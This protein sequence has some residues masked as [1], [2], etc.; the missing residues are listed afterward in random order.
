MSP[1]AQTLAQPRPK[2]QTGA[3]GDLVFE[4]SVVVPARRADV[5]AWHVRPGAFERLAPPWAPPRAVGEHPGVHDGSRVEFDVRLGPLPF[6]VRWV[7]EHEGVADAESAGDAG[8]ATRRHDGGSSGRQ[9]AL[10]LTRIAPVQLLGD[11]QREHGVAQELETLVG[12]HAAVL[13]AP[14][15]MGHRAFQEARISEVVTQTRRQRRELFAQCYDSSL[16][17]T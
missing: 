7:A 16:A 15:S 8:Q 10:G 2:A 9:D 11:D 5:W 3:M 1:P 17:V 4:R 12:R 14:R 13:R 6:H